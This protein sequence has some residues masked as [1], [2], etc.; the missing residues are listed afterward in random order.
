MTSIL[1]TPGSADA[2]LFDLGRVVIDIDFNRTLACWAGHA[3]CE[4]ADIV[5]RFVRDDVY[6]RHER[7][8]IDDVEFFAGLRAK[9][10]IDVTDA[11]FL[12]GWNAIFVGEM[13]GIA[14]LLARAGQRVPLYAF[15]NT[16]PAHVTHV[17][18]HFAD[19]LGHFREIFMSPTIGLRKPDAEAYDHVVKAIG[20][21]AQRIV[22][23]D[24]LMENIEGAR[25][26]G[27][28]AVHVTST[29]DVADALAALDL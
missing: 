12:E 9:L 13:A 8:E 18:Q 20:V 4:P 28:T 24:D 3:G 1:L 6:E 29:R 17:S 14:S 7:G 25:A 16:N 2:L 5:G 26:R 21:P 23:F 27:L 19:V 22:F 10:G 15:S 11:Q